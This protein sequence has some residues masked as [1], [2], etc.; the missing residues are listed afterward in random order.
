MMKLDRLLAIAILLVNRDRVSAAELAA[1]F[2]V[3]LRTIYRDMETI[4]QAGI[5]IVSF[6]GK[7]GGFSV[8]ESYR[9][10]RQVLTVKE[11]YSLIAA[12]RGVCRAVADPEINGALEKIQSLL[13]PGERLS[14]PGG[15]TALIDVSP[16]YAWRSE[17]GKTRLLQKAIEGCRLISFDYTNVKGESVTRIGRADDDGSQGTHPLSLRLLP[18]PGGLPV[19]QIIAASDLQLREETFVRRPV[20]MDEHAWRFWESGGPPIE[21]V[22]RFDARARV[23]V[24]DTF[25]P[26]QITPD[27]A[28]RLLVRGGFS[29]RDW[30][31][32]TIL[33]FGDLIEVLS[34]QKLRV[35]VMEKARGILRIYEG[36]T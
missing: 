6:Q 33:S 5:P 12:L 25:E 31:L 23:R 19:L 9:I 28:G 10:D 18:S 7:D 11:M 4:N 3:S 1:R 26:E 15:R 22:L 36:R 21:V 30:L 32:G 29:D 14:T 34:P 35:M 16:W 8:M 20:E 24:L 2:E 13:P 27:T 17:E